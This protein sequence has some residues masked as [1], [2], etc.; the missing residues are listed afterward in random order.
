MKSNMIQN[1]IDRK[2]TRQAEQHISPIAGLFF[3]I[4]MIISTLGAIFMDGKV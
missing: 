2:K 4:F 3:A 1:L